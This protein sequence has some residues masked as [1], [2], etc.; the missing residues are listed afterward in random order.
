M[1]IDMN[2][3]EKHPVERASIFSRLFFIWTYPILWKGWNKKLKVD[4]YTKIPSHMKTETLAEKFSNKQK[5]T[6]ALLKLADLNLT[7]NTYKPLR[8]SQILKSKKLVSSVV[9]VLKEE[10]INPFDADLDKDALLNFSSGRPIPDDASSEILRIREIG[11]EQYDDFVKYRIT[12]KDIGLH[13][14]ISRN[15]VKLFGNFNRKIVIKKS[16][17]E[18]SI[19]SN[20]NILGTLLAISA[21][22]ERAVNF[23]TALCYPLCPIPLSLANPDGS[24][25]ATAK[26]K[27]QSIVLKYSKEPVQHPRESLP[28][29]SQVSTFIVDLMA[30][31]CTIKELPDTYE[32]FTWKFLKSMPSGY[33]RIDIVADTYQD[34]SIKSGER[35]KRGSS[36]KI[37]IQSATSK[38]P[39]KFG[40]F[41]KNG[42][43]KRRLISLMK[44]VIVTNRLRV[45]NML[46]CTEMYIST[47]N[48]CTKLTLSSATEE[49]QLSSNQEE[50]D[51]K[52]LLH[53]Q[54]ALE[55]YPQKTVI[56]RSHSA[57]IDILVILLVKSEC[58]QIYLDSGTG[59]HRKGMRLSDI[60]MS[61]E[62]K[63]CLIG[64]HAFTGNDYNSSFFRKGKAACWKVLEKDEK[65]VSTF[66]ALG[67]DWNLAETVIEDLEEFVCLLYGRRQK[68]HGW[69]INNCIRWIEKA[70]PDELEDLLLT[71]ETETVYEDDEEKCIIL[72]NGEIDRENTFNIK[73]N[74][75]IGAITRI[76]HQGFMKT[77]TGKIMN[78]M[79]N[80]I[81]RFDM[82]Y[83]TSQYCISA[84]H[85]KFIT[86]KSIYIQ[87]TKKVMA[88]TDSRIKLIHEIITS[89]KIIKL[90]AWEDSFWKQLYVKRN[91][92]LLTSVSLKP[93][94]S[95][96]KN[97]SCKF[98]HEFKRLV[99]IAMYSG[100]S[101]IVFT[102]MSNIVI[103]FA[104]IGF[105][106]SNE[107]VI[108]VSK[109]Y[110]TITMFYSLSFGI[111]RNIRFHFVIKLYIFCFNE[112]YLNTI[113]CI[114]GLG[115]LDL[116]FYF[117]HHYIL[118]QL[119][120]INHAIEAL[121]KF[122]CIQLKRI[123][124]IWLTILTLSFWTFT[125][126]SIEEYQTENGN[127]KDEKIKK[128]RN[129]ETN[130]KPI[131]SFKD[132]HSSW[133]KDNENVVKGISFELNPG[134]YLCVI[135]EVGSGKTSLLKT[136]LKEMV[137]NRGIIKV[138]GKIA[139]ACQQ[140]WIFADTLK[141]N[142]IFGS[143]YDKEKY[144]NVINSC[145]LR[146][147]MNDM[148]NGD[149]TLVGERGIRLSGGQRA[150][151]SLA[152]ALYYDADIYLLDDPLS[153]VDAEV[154]NSLYSQCIQGYLS[155]KIRILVTH[156]VN[157]L[158]NAPKIL[159]LRKNKRP[160]IG[161]YDMLLEE[162]PELTTFFTDTS[163]E[164]NISKELTDNEQVQMNDEEKDE[165]ANL[166]NV[167]N[168]TSKSIPLKVYKEFFK[169][170]GYPLLIIPTS[171][172]LNFIYVSLVIGFDYW[173]K[174][175][176]DVEEKRNILAV[177]GK[178]VTDAVVNDFSSFISSL[179]QD[180]KYNIIVL[181]I[182]TV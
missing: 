44:E 47:E 61:T 64:F 20:R 164:N 38:A 176:T 139:Y 166:D 52:I 46:R 163:E 137:I 111:F 159:L 42:E 91:N 50:V 109:V 62:R 99:S 134:D 49:I 87:L 12:S 115:A 151:I 66:T 71:E 113:V 135:G 123:N 63:R 34:N 51:T 95:L 107:G 103:L 2:K 67:S 68:E 165:L 129:K 102:N 105:V 36:E 14:P 149:E 54:H 118:M 153:A 70:F 132:V 21:R 84:S 158:R 128:K 60:Q 90:Y 79:T 28:Q 130:L 89:M 45:L 154:G 35:D 162:C 23:K 180:T 78:I 59:L 8:P 120:C 146:K 56:V 74:F 6:D 156:Q 93:Y 100:A 48:N 141:N 19:E 138:S 126:L 167:E 179:V 106:Y 94:I 171:L 41:L 69:T 65:F 4:D 58:Q 31:I 117:I 96:K 150:R 30:S 55:R 169:A 112:R 161:T 24:R 83:K 104:M 75:E 10:Y 27:L 33:N 101:K 37:M 152:R 116:V 13:E 147:D 172:L 177:S 16:S 3:Y 121:N 77:N 32:D 57:D 88:A 173:I 25:K 22:N 15:K 40:D 174:T 170:A 182:I 168:A 148:P 76:S 86:L 39:R 178:N 108:S 29:K 131:I 98:I 73:I 53:C 144:Q 17:K 133:G 11:E 72:H 155:N 175:W 80:D 125:F 157:Y 136:V 140:S 119:V 18:K 122:F 110:L 43:N 145:C 97:P 124:L 9:R 160:I 82:I 5:N 142:I 127:T 85:H 143:K 181:A 114:F 81:N 92:K 7:D 26:S 1:T